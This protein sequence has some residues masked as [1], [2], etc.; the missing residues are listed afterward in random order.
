M[1]Y[2]ALILGAGN[3]ERFGKSDV[4]KALRRVQ[5]GEWSL[6]MAEHVIESLPKN[7]SADAIVVLRDDAPAVTF[8]H[9]RIPRTAS[10]NESLRKALQALS[11]D[12]TGV[13][14]H[15]LLVL[16]CDTLIDRRDLEGMLRLTDMDYR[17]IVAVD[18]DYRDENMSRVDACPFPR[19]FT[20]KDL[21]SPWGVVSARLFPVPQ[22]ALRLTHD[23]P[24]L[25]VA[26]NGLKG[27]TSS[28]PFLAYPLAYPWLD[29]GTPNRIKMTGAELV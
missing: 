5:Y 9:V 3:G 7:C 6:T 4:P 17:V 19:S 27:N 20:E 13:W 14:F 26:L 29:W 24:S 23:E 1:R 8:D 10:Q 21:S 18:K 12:N 16:D 28:T 15:P 22:D 25:T 2:T 11:D